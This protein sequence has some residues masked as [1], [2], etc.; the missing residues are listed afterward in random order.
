MGSEKGG[1]WGLVFAF[2]DRTTDGIKIEFAHSYEANENRKLSQLPRKLSNHKVLFCATVIFDNPLTPG[3]MPTPTPP[4]SELLAS[5]AAMARPW[6]SRRG[7]RPLP[8]AAWGQVARAEP[9]VSSGGSQ[10]RHHSDL[11]VAGVGR[12]HALGWMKTCRPPQHSRFWDVPC[13]S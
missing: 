4:L 5:P 10:S 7:A 8:V 13:I 11:G 9:C 1:V 3:P 2:R 6:S 12:A